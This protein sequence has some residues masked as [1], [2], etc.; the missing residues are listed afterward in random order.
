MS[1]IAGISLLWCGVCFVVRESPRDPG[2]YEHP[3]KKRKRYSTGF[4]HSHVPLQGEVTGEDDLPPTGAARHA[5]NVRNARRYQGQLHHSS[6]RTGPPSDTTVEERPPGRP[7]RHAPINDTGALDDNPRAPVDG[8]HTNVYDLSGAVRQHV[9]PVSHSLVDLNLP[10]ADAQEIGEKLAHV[11]VGRNRVAANDLGRLQEGAMRDT[12]DNQ[13]RRSQLA[14]DL[15][16]QPAQTLLVW[17]KSMRDKAIQFDKSAEANMIR[18]QRADHIEVQ[19]FEFEM[20]QR[21][22]EFR[23]R[24]KDLQSRSDLDRKIAMLPRVEEFDVAEILKRDRVSAATHAA[25]LRIA[26]REREI[27][28]VRSGTVQNKKSPFFVMELHSVPSSN[29]RGG[30]V[31]VKCVPDNTKPLHQW[32]PP[33]LSEQDWSLVRRSPVEVLVYTRG[34]KPGW[35]RWVLSGGLSMWKK[36]L[37]AAVTEANEGRWM[38][39]NTITSLAPSELTGTRSLMQFSDHR[40]LTTLFQNYTFL[41]MEIPWIRSVLEDSTTFLAHNPD[42]THYKVTKV[43]PILYARYVQDYL[44]F[45]N[46]VVHMKQVIRSMREDWASMLSPFLFNETIAAAAQHCEIY[47]HMRYL[48]SINRPRTLRDTNA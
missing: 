27:E 42:L 13:T 41:G 7:R 37:R 20:D 22:E 45:D 23:Q 5:Q 28:D 36:S 8:V 4:C 26:K 38:D 3:K 1:D 12:I 29:F 40:A 14:F 46:D 2:V 39:P 25:N 19:D 31:Q 30:M 47:A 32:K 15:A 6:R 11:Q 35:L 43:H 9:G 24:V 33:N 18:A 10:D 21:L 34:D 44:G 16:S 48:A 17:N